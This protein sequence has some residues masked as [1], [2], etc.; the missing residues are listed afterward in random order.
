MTLLQHTHTRDVRVADNSKLAAA[1]VSHVYFC[2]N[3]FVVLNVVVIMSVKYFFIGVENVKLIFLP[4]LFLLLF[5][6]VFFHTF[7]GY[8]VACVVMSQVATRRLGYCI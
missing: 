1:V 5:F 6:S 2:C 3:C 7:I 4:F 8:F